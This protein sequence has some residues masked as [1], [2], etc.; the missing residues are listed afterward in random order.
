MGKSKR[1]QKLIREVKGASSLG[2]SRFTMKGK[3]Q[4]KGFTGG[5]D[6]EKVAKNRTNNKRRG[7]RFDMLRGAKDSPI[8]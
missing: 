2:W 4:R 1:E 3:R 6:D 5:G 7:R 8:Q